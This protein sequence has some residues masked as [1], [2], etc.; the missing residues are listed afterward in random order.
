MWLLILKKDYSTP[1]CYK[2]YSWFFKPPSRIRLALTF[3]KKVRCWTMR[4]V[5]SVFP[6]PLS[7]LMTMHWH[8]KQSGRSPANHHTETT[9]TFGCGFSIQHTP[10]YSSMFHWTI[11]LSWDSFQYMM[12]WDSSLSLQSLDIA[13]SDGAIVNWS[14]WVFWSILVINCIAMNHH[15]HR[16]LYLHSGSSAE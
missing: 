12:S 15:I 6:D 16:S 10:L 2:P 4:W 14:L 5:L 7:P 11:I 13:L 9:C 3:P 8:R 1:I